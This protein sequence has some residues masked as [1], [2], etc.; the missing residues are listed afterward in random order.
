MAVFHPT[1]PHPSLVSAR[2][3][4]SLVFL[5]VLLIASTALFYLLPPVVWSRRADAAVIFYPSDFWLAIK[6]VMIPQLHSLSIG[7]IV[8]YPLRVAAAFASPLP[9]SLLA[10][11]V[12]LRV[13]VAVAIAASAGRTVFCRVR[14]ASV[15]QI[16]ARHVSGPKPMRG[17][18]GAA[19]LNQ[20]WA[21]LCRQ[22]GAGLLLAPDVRLPVV[23]EKQGI[24]LVGQP[25]AGKSV[26]LEGL[27]RQ[28]LMRKDRVIALDVKGG[29]AKRIASHKPAVLGL[30][31]PTSVV[32]AIGED[33]LTDAD[34]DEFAAALIP[35]SKDPVWSEGSRLILAALVLYLAKRHGPRWGW[36]HLYR[37][38]TQPLE[39]LE[40]MV[41]KIAPEVANMIQTRGEEPA[42]F[43]LSLL[44][45]MTAHVG[46]T[47]RR[48]ARLESAGARRLSLRSWVTATGRRNPIVLRYD[49]QRRERSANFVKLA[50]RLL[51]G[52]LLGDEVEDGRDAR[53]WLFLDEV[54]RVGRS[55]ALIDLVSL[56]RSRGV[57]N[58]VS[59]QSPAQLRDTYGDA[60]SEALRENF[61]L[62]IICALPPGDNARRIANDWVAPRMVCDPGYVRQNGTRGEWTI[63][64]ISP[65]EYATD[66]GLKFDLWGRPYIRAAVLGLGDIP[67]LDWPL[68]RWLPRS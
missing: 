51:A 45:N 42:T 37:M 5:G 58:V 64:P 11:P 7:D 24:L 25:G 54:T 62:Q 56:G 13:A 17:Q 38:V 63:P 30:S 57:R 27:L 6:Q 60:G 41:R 10:L 16:S 55:D 44:F 43:I 46:A 33:L 28:A 21:P 20:V 67:V 65:A 48:F 12:S 23:T 50:L 40:K 15:K 2:F 36:R 4:S 52:A 1:E 9:W 39:R 68:H 31:G 22:T 61:G 59:L 14:D 32:W 29:L 34:A 26:I 19:H 47:V 8:S 49:L 18:W 66:F 3:W 53:V 35:E